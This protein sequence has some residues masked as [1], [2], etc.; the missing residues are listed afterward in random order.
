M[1]VAE[2]FLSHGEPCTRADALGNWLTERY[3]RWEFLVVFQRQ[4]SRD[5]RANRLY[6]PVFHMLFASPF[7]DAG[8]EMFGAAGVAPWQLIFY[9]LSRTCRDVL[10]GT[11]G[12]DL[13]SDVLRA[14][15]PAL[16][17]SIFS[18]VCVT[19]GDTHDRLGLF[20]E[21]AFR[22]YKERVERLQRP[23]ET[24]EVSVKLHRAIPRGRMSKGRDDG[25]LPVFVE[26]AIKWA[27]RRTSEAADVS[28][29]SQEGNDA[30]LAILPRL[31]K[32]LY[33]KTFHMAEDHKFADA[34]SGMGEG[35]NRSLTDRR[36]E[37]RRVFL[38]NLRRRVGNVASFT[39]ASPTSSEEAGHRWHVLIIQ[40]PFVEKEELS[41][42]NL[43]PGPLEPQPVGAELH[44]LQ[45]GGEVL[46]LQ[47]QLC[48]ENCFE[49][50]YGDMMHE[51][52]ELF[53]QL[54][55]LE[56]IAFDDIDRYLDFIL[57]QP[58]PFGME[59]PTEPLCKGSCSGY[60]FPKVVFR[61]PTG[62]VVKDNLIASPHVEILEESPRSPEEWDA[63]KRVFLFLSDHI[64]PVSFAPDN[65]HSDG[66][67]GYT[68][69]KDVAPVQPP[70]HNDKC[71]WCGRRRDKLLRCGGCKVD[72]YC[73][74]KHQMMDWKGGHKKY[75]GI[76]RKAR[77]EYE[78][79]IV[80]LLHSCPTERPETRS[81][82]AVVTLLQFLMASWCELQRSEVSVV[83]IVG[84]DDDMTGFL[85][86][87]S[88]RAKNF[89]MHWKQLRLLLS[90]D[91]FGDEEHNA[92]YAINEGGELT[93]TAPTSALGDVWHT[94]SGKEEG[95]PEAVMLVRL[96]NAKYH[97]FIGQ[98][99]EISG[100]APSAVASFGNPSGAGMT[101]LTAVAEVLA[102]RFIGV[103]PVICTEPTLF[104]AHHTLDAI[105]ERVRSSNKMNA[106]RKERV[107]E[108]LL[109]ADEFIRINVQGMG[110]EPLD[111]RLGGEG[112]GVGGTTQTNA[113]E[114][115]T[116]L[117]PLR[118]HP[119][120]YYFI[121]PA[122]TAEP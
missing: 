7:S 12:V 17:P 46:Y 42:E 64:A 53:A 115:A 69:T 54:T 38:Q 57:T 103:V 29:P 22:H 26:D 48:S 74:R 112:G 78:K 52:G 71:T 91:T 15:P 5:R 110:H 62:S 70:T 96:Y 58:Q 111:S 32:L 95:A 99:T 86:E 50:V 119:N 75:C 63:A 121:I 92:V 72:M 39:L 107:I 10:W 30:I 108:R 84:I 51:D 105:L 55:P 61:R 34:V 85:S 94:Q 118:L 9:D 68:L 28:A 87:L 37:E 120:L 18:V 73:C 122:E 59:T 90:S 25:H 79:S 8:R 117:A 11:K 114:F 93:K 100:G 47:S 49:T 113:A 16:Q 43:D 23:Q 65:G 45:D 77:E 80:P 88:Q 19:V 82:S 44:L 21:Q 102:D 101:Y 1:S 31:N 97:I 76:W 116:K 83:H 24:P 36:L 104:G 13:I 35:E 67:G 4:W 20:S 81:A 2:G 27:C 109:H 3:S 14:V 98:D 66:C 40:K 33:K 6:A 89:S 60:T 106:D 56:G 41:I